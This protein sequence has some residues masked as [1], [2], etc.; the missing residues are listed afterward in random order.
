[1][2][3]DRTF[4]GRELLTPRKPVPDD[5]YGSREE[6]GALYA[7][8]LDIYK[9]MPKKGLV[10]EPCIFPWYKVE[11]SPGMVLGQLAL[12]AYILQDEEKITY[13]AGLLGKSPARAGIPAGASSSTFSCM[14]QGTGSRGRS[15]WD[16]WAMQKNTQPKGPMQS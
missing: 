3:T 8:F 5:I 1:M 12:L 15:F 16:M 9:R 14:N 13:M 10:Y 7:V 6:A 4:Y 2:F 11:L